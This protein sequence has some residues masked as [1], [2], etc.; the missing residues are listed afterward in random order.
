MQ[1]VEAKGLLVV[2][3][4]MVFVLCKMKQASPTLTFSLSAAI[5]PG[6]N[7]CVAIQ[8]VGKVNSRKTEKEGQHVK[9]H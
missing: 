9:Q 3:L 2:N 7:A 1:L 6:K 4:G 8:E 5:K